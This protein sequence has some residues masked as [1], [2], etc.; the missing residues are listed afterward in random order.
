MPPKNKGKNKGKKVLMTIDGI[1][2]ISQPN[3]GQGSARSKTTKNTAAGGVDQS[4]DDSSFAFEDSKREE[5]IVGDNESSLLNESQGNL[6]SLGG[7]STVR[8]GEEGK[9]GFSSE[10][11]LGD[12][13]NQ[14]DREEISPMKTHPTAKDEEE[15]KE[16]MTKDL[17]EQHARRLEEERHYLE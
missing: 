8:D 7:N 6:S 9:L 14:I 17:L 12:L 13:Q 10:K 15:E 16:R 5:D 2:E 3:D 11:M 1:Q 4:M